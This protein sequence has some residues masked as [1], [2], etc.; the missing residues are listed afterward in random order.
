MANRFNSIQLRCESEKVVW[1][2]DR[3]RMRS[4]VL[5]CSFFIK[6]S[7][8]LKIQR[9]VEQ[10]KNNETLSLNF[11]IFEVISYEHC[12]DAIQNGQSTRFKISNF[13]LI[14]LLQM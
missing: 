14:F 1:Y 9:R 2:S 4:A 10:D 8:P 3:F 12:L 7:G 13:N 5:I 6:S 11:Y